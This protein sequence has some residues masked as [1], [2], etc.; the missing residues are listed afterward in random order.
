M[1]TDLQEK[2]CRLKKSEYYTYFKMSALTNK[3]TNEE[4]AKIILDKEIITRIEAKEIWR[5]V[6]E[7]YTAKYDKRKWFGQLYANGV[8]AFDNADDKKITNWFDFV[9]SNGTTTENK[10]DSLTDSNN[11]RSIKYANVGLI[12]LILYLNDKSA[13]SIWFEGQHE[14]LRTLFPA[15]DRF[16]GVGA[17]YVEFNKTLKDFAK[18]NAFSHT[19]LDFV[20]SQI[21]KT[22]SVTPNPAKQD[23]VQIKVFLPTKEDVDAAELKLRKTS[24]VEKTDIETVLNQVKQ[25]FEKADKLLK[26]N[27]RDITKQNILIWF[28]NNYNRI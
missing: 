19:E 11:P 21:N 20:L 10:I 9:L 25:D 28:S 14:A 22:T 5:L 15:I 16:N 27:W 6:N 7:P 24:S 2:V 1:S 3:E 12:T 26:E 13:H 18:N 8:R 23:H 17:Q 4:L